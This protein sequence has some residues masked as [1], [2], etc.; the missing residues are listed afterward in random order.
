MKILEI[1]PNE[2]FEINTA[3]ETTDDVIR[4]SIPSDIADD[5]EI[6][7]VITIDGNEYP[8]F[9]NTNAAQTLEL[10]MQLRDNLNMMEDTSMFGSEE[11]YINCMDTIGTMIEDL[12]AESMVDDQMSDDQSDSYEEEESAL[13]I[14][15][16]T[17]D[18]YHTP[19]SSVNWQHN[20]EHVDSIE[21]AMCTFQ[22]MVAEM[23]AGKRSVEDVTNTAES[24]LDNMSVNTE[25]EFP[26]AK[27]V[28][29]REMATIKMFDAFAAYAVIYAQS[30]MHRETIHCF[31]TMQDM[32]N[33]TNRFVQEF[34]N[35]DNDA[36]RK[37]AIE[38]MEAF[39]NGFSFGD[40]SKDEADDEAIADVM[41]A[42]ND[43]EGGDNE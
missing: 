12:M 10:F 40:E 42:A 6:C 1:K 43:I 39:L 25:Y 26:M 22:T 27:D 8:D 3:I 5:G 24:V 36:A 20:A 41:E 33:F 13:R 29:K 17:G 9:D 18:V 23:Y 16:T 32:V 34:K 38:N 11:N 14:I 2:K 7:T 31:N 19:Y 21:E 28:T 37:S 35:A 30:L 4:V 15:T